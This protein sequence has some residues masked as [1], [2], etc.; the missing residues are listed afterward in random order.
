MARLLEKRKQQEQIVKAGLREH[1]MCVKELIL[2]IS[3]LESVSGEQV[4]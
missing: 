4:D 1:R 2:N 3:E